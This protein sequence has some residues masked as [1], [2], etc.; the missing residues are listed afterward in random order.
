MSKIYEALLRAELERTVAGGEPTHA[1]VA[2]ARATE[3]LLNPE[4]AEFVPTETD[5]LGPSYTDVTSTSNET[6]GQMLAPVD[7]S[8]V[9]RRP[10]SPQL[11]YMPALGDRGQHVEQFRSLRSHIFEARD[12]AP[13]KTLVISSGLP[14]EG[15][16]FVT[17]NTALSFSRHKSNR[18]LLIDGDM[19][20]SSL[21]KLLGTTRDPGLSDFLAG[22]KTL[23]EVMQ[24]CETTPRSTMPPG[25]TSLTFIAGG[26]EAENA[27]DLAAHPRFEELIATASTWFDWIFIDSPPVNLVSDAVSLAR[28]CHGVLLVA[29]EGTTRFKTAQNAQAQFKTTPVL[30]FVLNAVSKLPVKGDYYGGYDAYKPEG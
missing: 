11:V 20:R 3:T 28:S 6:L 16:S 13:L 27:G 17:L 30:G 15:K 2:A 5:P 12:A 29:R 26:R 24:R 8:E 18:V 7:F 22:N 10:W 21:H 4:P 9:P 1:S 14:G 19:R 25:L 23:L